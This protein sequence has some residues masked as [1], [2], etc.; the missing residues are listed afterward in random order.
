VIDRFKEA[1]AVALVVAACG[2][3]APTDSTLDKRCE[4]FD[5]NMDSGICQIYLDRDNWDANPNRPVEDYD[6]ELH[7]Y[8]G[9]DHEDT[10]SLDDQ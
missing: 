6:E 9:E 7:R 10:R 3:A 5:P 8:D 2:G 4:A 1:C